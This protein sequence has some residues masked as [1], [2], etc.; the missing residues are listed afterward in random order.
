[1][2]IKTTIEP[3]K[4]GKPV[5]EPLES[6]NH[7]FA[8]EKPPAPMPMIRAVIC[9]LRRTSGTSKAMIRTDAITSVH[10]SI[11][12]RNGWMIRLVNT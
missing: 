11:Q 10:D 4:P 6:V 5:I 1:M 2:R 8:R 3:A 9:R 12:P 7:P